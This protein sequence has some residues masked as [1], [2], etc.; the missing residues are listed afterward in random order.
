MNEKRLLVLYCIALSIVT[1][2][3][4]MFFI[5]FKPTSVCNCVSSE[6]NRLTKGPQKSCECGQGL[7]LT[8]TCQPICPWNTTAPLGC[9]VLDY[10][11]TLLQCGSQ[12]SV[13]H[14]Y[15]DHHSESVDLFIT[16][17][18]LSMLTVFGWIILC[19]KAGHQYMTEWHQLQE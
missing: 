3:F 18:F 11:S 16:I 12:T 2:G 1:L 10:D 14:M 19:C 15:P 17:V 6:I 5:F 13:F 7:D 8:A 9:I 4:T